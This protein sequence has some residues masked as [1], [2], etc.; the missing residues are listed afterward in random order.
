MHKKVWQ[1]KGRGSATYIVMGVMMLLF[2]NLH[3]SLGGKKKKEE[4]FLTIK[5]H[6]CS[7]VSLGLSQKPPPVMPTSLFLPH[8]KVSG[9]LGTHLV[10]PQ[11]LD[12]C[13]NTVS[14]GAE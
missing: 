8:S 6:G 3:H 7:V 13:L 4:K 5:A 1:K 2:H 12:R 11:N 14:V 9:K 10:N